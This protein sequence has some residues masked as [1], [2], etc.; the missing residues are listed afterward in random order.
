MSRLF[1]RFKKKV[2]DEGRAKISYQL[3]YS[4]CDAVHKW[5]QRG[6]IPKRKQELVKSLLRSKE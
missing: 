5:I 1:V 3:G 2:N 6:E 4:S